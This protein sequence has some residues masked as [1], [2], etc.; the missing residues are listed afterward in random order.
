MG[1]LPFRFHPF[2]IFG[3]HKIALFHS[4]RAHCSNLPAPIIVDHGG[5]FWGAIDMLLCGK[6]TPILRSTTDDFNC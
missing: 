5:N 2:L 6:S 4:F 3:Y 1:M